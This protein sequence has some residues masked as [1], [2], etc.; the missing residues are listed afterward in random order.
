VENRRTLLLRKWSAPPS[1]P[2]RDRRSVAGLVR[3]IEAAETMQELE[4]LPTRD[5]V[6]DENECRA[7]PLEF[8]LRPAFGDV[9]GGVYFASE[10]R[11]S[12]V[13]ATT[14]RA[15]ELAAEVRAIGGREL[16]FE[17]RAV[18]WTLVALEELHERILEDHDELQR[19]GIRMLHIGESTECNAVEV[20]VGSDL[21]TAEDFLRARFRPGPIVVVRGHE[22]SHMPGTQ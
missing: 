21:Q 4:A 18:D 11:T 6:L 12:L 15:A 22:L 14:G 17:L 7:R 20:G 3:A 9:F 1:V 2:R 8:Q 16:A 13:V 19:R 10:R 5:V